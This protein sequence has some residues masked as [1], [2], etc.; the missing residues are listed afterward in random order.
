MAGVQVLGGSLFLGNVPFIYGSFFRPP[1]HPITMR[2][3]GLFTTPGDTVYVTVFGRP[4][5]AVGVPL[6]TAT[7]LRPQESR[8]P[9]SSRAGSR[10]EAVRDRA[11]THRSFQAFGGGVGDARPRIPNPLQVNP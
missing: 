5:V 7:A 6:G 8:H 4:M 3:M 11:T 9:G 1:A 2:P 10:T